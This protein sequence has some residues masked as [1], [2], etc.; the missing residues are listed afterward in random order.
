MKTII[1]R[2]VAV[3]LLMVSISNGSTITYQYDNLHRLTRV[4]GSD[5]TVTVYEYDELGNRT[6]KVTTT[7]PSDYYCDSDNDGYIDSTSDGTCNGYGC[8][9][10]GCQT[11]A[12][13]DCD[14]DDYLEHPNQTW[15]ADIDVDGYS[16]GTTNTTSCTRPLGYKVDTELK[17][18][19]G[20]CDD[21]DPVLNPETY[22]YPDADGDGYGDPSISIQ[23]CTQPTGPPVYVLDN[24]DYDDSDPN[25]Y[26]GGPPVRISGTTPTYYPSLQDAYNNAV[27]GDTIQ[28]QA[29]I[30]T[31]DLFINLNKS[32]LL[33]GGYDGAFTTNS[34]NTT[35][36][37]NM[38]IS[39]GT[40]TTEN[41]IIGN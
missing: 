27:D 12:G 35:L 13:D 29:V 21:G 3:L 37:G 23:Q 5:G 14:D 36:N 1:L 10:E 15:Y 9:P 16:D 30:F 41:L 18:T 6:L 28:V 33:E 26:P 25:I 19:A 22:W 20:D 40:I 8:E 32:V 7:E 2:I 11:V 17:A 34:G 38:T 39:N 4:E 31:E 24:T